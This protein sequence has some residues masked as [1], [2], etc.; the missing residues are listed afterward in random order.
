MSDTARSAPA[1]AVLAALSHDLMAALEPDGRVAWANDSWRRLLGWAPEELAGVA[2][3]DLVEPADADA[4]RALARDGG[5]AVLGVSTRSGGT[6]RMAFSAAAA[7][8]VI[9][10]CGRD[11]TQTRELEHELQAAED[12]FR[13]LTEATPEAICVADGRGRITFANRGATA[14]FGWEPHELLGQPFTILVPER[15]RAV[16]QGHLETFLATGYQD[17][18]GRTLELL[19]ARKDGSEFPM[20]A[21]LGFWE[22]SGRSAFTGIMRDVSERNETLA[23]LELSRARYRALVANLP[24]V[25]VALFDNEERLLVMEGGQMARRGLHPGQYEGRML[26]DALEP[27]AGALISPRVRAALGGAEQQF[28]IEVRDVVYEVHIAP[29]RGD[30]GRAIGA[31]AVARDI[32][33]LREAQRSLEE[34]ARELERSNAELAEFAYVASHDLSE[35]LR[36]ITSYL[37]LLRRRHGGELEGEADGYVGRAI[38]SAERLHSLI[39]DLLAYSRVGRAERATE[40]VDIEAIVAAIAANVTATREPTPLIEFSGLPTVPG[41]QR[42]LTQLLQ[43]LISNAIKF[44]PEGTVPEVR[45]SAVLEEGAW[46]ITVDDNGIGIDPTQAERVFGMFQRLHTRDAFPGTGIGLAIARKVVEGH[47]GRIWAEPRPE[48][49]TRMAF[50]LPGESPG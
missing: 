14:I 50:T 17:L 29:L 35:P 28:E 33:V 34:R 49:G 2:L 32:T 46:R 37:R 12:R 25:I 6:R 47:G 18:L 21:A 20:E 4:V 15:F 42:A 40:P 30:D 13:A 45:L 9:Y 44:V 38:D 10:V 3:A 23:A 43:N 16:W 48:G 41:Q 24:Q 8:G 26:D 19:G 39:D 31:V 1:A 36:T 27:G 7:E 11:A 22:R 5:E